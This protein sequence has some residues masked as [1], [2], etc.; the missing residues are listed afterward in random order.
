MYRVGKDVRALEERALEESGRDPTAR[1][2]EIEEGGSISDQDVGADEI[3]RRAVGGAAAREPPSEP[4]RREE[5]RQPASDE[6]SRARGERR[7]AHPSEAEGKMSD[8]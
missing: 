6:S 2:G 8:E 7:R 3:Q 5:G 1:R 4:G